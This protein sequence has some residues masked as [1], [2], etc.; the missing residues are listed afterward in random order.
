MF[1]SE[2]ERLMRFN[3]VVVPTD[4][5]I[6]RSKKKIPSKAEFSDSNETNDRDGTKKNL[7][8]FSRA[9]REVQA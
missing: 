6:Y 3:S 2:S 1:I 9:K 4:Q 7:L 5:R 8:L